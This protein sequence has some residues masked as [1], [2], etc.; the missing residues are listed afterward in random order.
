MSFGPTA[1]NLITD[2]KKKHADARFETD[3]FSVTIRDHL[4]RLGFQKATKRD[5]QQIILRAL[6]VSGEDRGPHSANHLLS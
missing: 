6:S 4:A 1:R 5:L 3:V 2:T